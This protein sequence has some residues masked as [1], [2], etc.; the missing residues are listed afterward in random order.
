MLKVTDYGVARFIDNDSDQTSEQ[1]ET[2][3]SETQRCSF[4]VVC[5]D[6]AANYINGCRNVI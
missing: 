3:K 2:Y 5:Y 6:S 1:Q 4:H